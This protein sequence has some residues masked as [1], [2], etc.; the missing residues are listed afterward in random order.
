M[1]WCDRCWLFAWSSSVMSLANSLS[2]AGKMNEL[3]A[4]SGRIFE[5]CRVEVLCAIEKRV[6][7][8]D[9]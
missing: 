1:E 7:K 2:Q 4:W 9:L 5:L 8:T 3:A 6:S